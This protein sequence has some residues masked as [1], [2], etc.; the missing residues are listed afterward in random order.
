MLD[1]PKFPWLPQGVIMSTV[2]RPV[3]NKHKVPKRAWDKWTRDA[4]KLFNSV[5]ES[6]RPSMQAVMHHPDASPLPMK[7]WQVLRWNVAW[8]AAAEL[9]KAQKV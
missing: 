8:T 6:L 3:S 2:G 7:H 5:Y 4:Q 9:T 1:S